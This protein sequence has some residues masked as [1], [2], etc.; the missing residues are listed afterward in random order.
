M[1]SYGLD[2]WFW[3]MFELTWTWP[4]FTFGQLFMW[5][6]TKLTRYDFLWARWVILSNV[7][8]DLNFTT[9]SFGQLLMWIGANNYQIWLPMGYMS[10]S[11]QCSNRLEFDLIS[12]LLNFSCELRQTMTRYIYISFISYY[13]YTYKVCTSAMFEL[14]WTTRYDFL[15]AR[16]VILSNVWTDLNLT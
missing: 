8:T 9:G 10:D 3:A 5:I 2:E 4:N 12:L 13:I 7:R 6:G 1:T 15:C 14:T 16:W 11:E